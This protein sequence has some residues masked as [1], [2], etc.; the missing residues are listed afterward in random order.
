MPGMTGLWQVTARARSTFREALEMDVVYATSWSLRLD[1]L[2]LARTP[3]QL[4]RLK[5]TT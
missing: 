2:L 3:A 1:L 4:I 5:S